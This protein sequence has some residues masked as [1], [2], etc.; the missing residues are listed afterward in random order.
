MTPGFSLYEWVQNLLS[1]RRVSRFLGDLG[2]DSWFLKWE[3]V[4]K[5]AVFA[6]LVF[7]SGCSLNQ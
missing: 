4:G 5:R 1:V 3:S 2:N 6:G 7:P